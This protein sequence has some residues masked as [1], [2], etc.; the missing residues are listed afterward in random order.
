MKSL[1]KRAQGIKSIITQVEADVKR[2]FRQ[3][4]IFLAMVKGFFPYNKKRLNRQKVWLKLKKMVDLWLKS[5]LKYMCKQKT[6]T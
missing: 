2:F 3:E 1:T 5:V 4:G 6:N